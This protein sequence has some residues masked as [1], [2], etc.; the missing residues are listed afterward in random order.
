MFKLS[1]NLLLNNNSN[2]KN[3]LGQTDIYLLDQIIKGRYQ[4]PDKILDAGCGDGRN[5]HWFLQNNM[6]ITGIDQNEEVIT[7]LKISNPTLPKSR[8]Q[9]CRVE[10]IPLPDNYFDHVIC[11]AVLHFAAGTNHFKEMLA[12]IVRVTRQGGSIFIRMASNIGIEDKV[13]LINDGVY[14]IPDGSKRFLLNKALLAESME[15][16]NLSL[17][18]PLKTVNVND[19]RCMSTL[20]LQKN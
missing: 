1:T 5:M 15:L 7:Q 19:I 10:T 9:V 13:N 17:L 8:L 18:E 3:L 2:I 12:E 6:A 14:N 20:V 16:L 11:S 4:A